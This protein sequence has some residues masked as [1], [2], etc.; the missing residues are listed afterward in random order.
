MAGILPASYGSSAA[1]PG[2]TANRHGVEFGHNGAHQACGGNRSGAASRR[3]AANSRTPSRS[4]TGRGPALL[5]GGHPGGSGQLPEVAIVTPLKTVV[6]VSEG[7]AIF[8]T[9]RGLAVSP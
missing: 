7:V 4:P 2:L 8:G 9:G 1:W 6:Q 5:P 3:L